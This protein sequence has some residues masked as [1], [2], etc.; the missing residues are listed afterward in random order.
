MTGSYTDR[1]TMI[2]LGVGMSTVECGIK[3]SLLKLHPT[4][5][6]LIQLIVAK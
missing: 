2:G 5:Q 4:P 6:F 3:S 1:Q